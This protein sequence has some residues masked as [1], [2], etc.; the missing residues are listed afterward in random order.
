MKIILLCISLLALTACDFRDAI[1]YTIRGPK[2]KVGE[3]IASKMNVREFSQREPWETKKILYV[4][5]VVSLGK[6]KYRTA[7]VVSES[8]VMYT[9]TSYVMDRYYQT[10]DCPPIL[11]LRKL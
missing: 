2:F 1:P 5:K 11:K 8:M 6:D 10:V 9:T 7:A 3:C 4:E